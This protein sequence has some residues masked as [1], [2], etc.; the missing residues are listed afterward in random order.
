M[1]L[2]SPF[3][4]SFR[5]PI[6]KNPHTFVNP[7]DEGKNKRSSKFIDGFINRRENIISN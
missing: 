7:S 2:P 3:D 6:E 1:H 5:F 4:P